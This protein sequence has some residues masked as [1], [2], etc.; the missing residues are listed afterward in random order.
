MKAINKTKFICAILVLLSTTFAKNELV[1]VGS[2]TVL[3]IAQECAEIFMDKNP[4]VNLTVRGGGSGVGIAALI[5]KTCDIAMSSRA[6]KTKEMAN[7]RA[8]GINPVEH[9]IA[10]DCIVIVVHP[11]VPVENLTLEQLRDIYTGK[12]QNWKELGGPSKNIVVVSRDVASGTYEVFK[13]KVLKDKTESD[14]ALKAASNQAVLTTV[15]TTPFSIGYIGLGYLDE[16]VKAVKVEGVAPS[17]ETAK[18]QRYPIVRPLYLVT[19]GAPKETAKQF[20][21]FVLSTDGQKI[22][23]KLGFVPVK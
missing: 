6:V 17:K 1:I 3:P 9:I 23:D 5:D 7:A 14:N 8:K 12:T 2:T 16:K 4:N 18:S 10:W 11:E 22:V 13:E 20:I 15:A 21:D 19:N